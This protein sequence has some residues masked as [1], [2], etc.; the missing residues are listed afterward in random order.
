MSPILNQPENIIQF[1][2]GYHQTYFLDGKGNV[3]SVGFNAFGNLGLGHNTT[4]NILNQIPNIPPIQSISSVGY[5]CYLLDFEGNVW[6]FGNTTGRNDCGQLGTGNMQSYSIPT[7]INL[8]EN[9]IWGNQ[10]IN[11]WT[12]FSS[13]I[14]NW[15]EEE[16]ET[17]EM[18]QSKIQNVK[19]NL[20]SNNNNKIKQEF[21]QNSFESWNEVDVFLKEK[22]EEI[23]SKKTKKQ[24][25]ELQ[26]QKNVETFE[27]EL[28]DIENQLQLLQERKKEIEENLLPKAKQS[29]FSLK[30]N[31][32]EIEK[33]Q[34]T[35]GEMRSDVS[36]FCKNET[37]MNEELAKLYSKK[38]FEEFDCSDISKLLW[39]MD[40]TKYQQVFEANQI[41]GL[42][43]SAM[44]FWFWD[45]FGVEKQ[46]CFKISFNFKMM[47]LAG[48]SKTFSPDYEHD[49]CVCYHGTS[50]K[51]VY[52]LKEYEIPIAEDVILKNN[53]CS[54]MLTCKTFLKDILGKDYCSQNGVQTILKLDEWKKI[55]KR[56]LKD[57]EKM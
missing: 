1:C 38:K 29:Q 32:I 33:K 40:L 48:Y 10:E 54:S 44:D 11:E 8:Q 39:K 9:Q 21:P 37:E 6:S 46:D 35:L 34:K 7:E 3:F 56:H 25:I 45:Q 17:L 28:K 41:N 16:I 5:S 42:A 52:L 13:E 22:L 18:I 14:M 4:Q 31:F 30:E 23:N 26:N 49:C 47:K 20:E 12:H 24:E 15:K 43:A 36:I 57:L 27:N 55:H 53:Y 19:F 2:C 50:K 51:T